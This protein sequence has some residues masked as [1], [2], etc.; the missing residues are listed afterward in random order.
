MGQKLVTVFAHQLEDQRVN[1]PR[2]SC[3]ASSER[4]DDTPSP[5][6]NKPVG[7]KTIAHGASRRRKP[8]GNIGS[9]VKPR[10]GA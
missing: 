10:K 7:R 2:V 6:L 1:Q 3:E 9:A 5:F 8:W 4:T